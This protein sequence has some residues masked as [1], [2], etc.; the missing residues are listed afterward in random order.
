MF[1]VYEVMYFFN[2]K[3]V[4]IP[5]KAI[6]IIFL[7][8]FTWK[9]TLSWLIIHSAWH[10]NLAHLGFSLSNKEPVVPTGV[11]SC[12]EVLVLDAESAAQKLLKKL[13]LH[14]FSVGMCEA[15]GKATWFYKLKC[16]S[17]VVKLMWL[18]S[19]LLLSCSWEVLNCFSYL[20]QRKT[21]LAGIVASD[22]LIV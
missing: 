22:L 9:F 1:L 10:P 14:T 19:E 11:G 3:N 18:R 20:P 21:L 17:N 2:K 7:C 16:P 6:D 15:A 12:A 4:P 13:D 8:L 5:V